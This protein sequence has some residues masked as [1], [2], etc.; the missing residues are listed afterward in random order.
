M[1]KE[2]RRDRGKKEYGNIEERI[3]ELRGIRRCLMEMAVV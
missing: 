2:R 1:F 3:G